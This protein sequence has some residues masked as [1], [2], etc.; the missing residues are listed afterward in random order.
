MKQGWAKAALAAA[1]IS[2]LIQGTNMNAAQA[3]PVT[4]VASSHQAAACTRD[5]QR[6][7]L[8]YTLA[9][10]PHFYWHT[11]KLSTPELQTAFLRELEGRVAN[12]L[13]T[14]WKKIVAQYNSTDMREG[15]VS[16]QLDFLRASHAYIDSYGDDRTSSPNIE[17]DLTGGTVVPD[18]AFCPK[19]S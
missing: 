8:S 5:G 17:V 11:Q 19:I 18:P 2:G 12:P 4:G 9:V 7:T 3:G 1:A 10:S 16:P 13:N 14:D 6:A 15:R